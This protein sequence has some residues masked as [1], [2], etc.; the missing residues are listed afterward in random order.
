MSDLAVERIVQRVHEYFTD[1]PSEDY[2]TYDFGRE[3]A[4][5]LPAIYHQ[6]VVRRCYEALSGVLAESFLEGFLELTALPELGNLLLD[7]IATTADIGAA[8]GIVRLAQ[9]FGGLTAQQT[10]DGIIER[11][12]VATDSS[13]QDRL[14]YAL[15][16][17]LCC[18]TFHVA[19]GQTTRNSLVLARQRILQIISNNLSLSQYARSTLEECLSKT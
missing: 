10:A 7:R 5:T 19:T 18:E 16:C 13:Q 9:E 8:A 14:A 11:F 15:R 6:D 4:R 1:P 12:L 3:I 2:S 17:V